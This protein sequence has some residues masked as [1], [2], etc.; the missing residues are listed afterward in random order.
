M[1]KISYT[2]GLS[3]VQGHQGL[4]EYVR[5]GRAQSAYFRRGRPRYLGSVATNQQVTFSQISSLWKCCPP[6]IKELWQA[7]SKPGRTPL[8]E[9]FRWNYFRYKSFK[10]YDLIFPTLLPESSLTFGRSESGFTPCTV[11]YTVGLYEPDDYAVVVHWNKTRKYGGI[12]L[13]GTQ[14]NR[15]VTI[16]VPSKFD[17]RWAFAIRS[18]SAW[19]EAWELPHF[20]TSEPPM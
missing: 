15:I 1:V 19:S 17:K 9:F 12:I 14:S 4:T 6:F 2:P 8:A 20:N 5:P 10:F 7:V 11:T 18:N 16:K 13:N 3:G